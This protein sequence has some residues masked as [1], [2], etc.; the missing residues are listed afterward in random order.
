MSYGYRAVLPT[1]GVE[2]MLAIEIVREAV[3]ARE[4]LAEIRATVN[5]ALASYYAG[6]ALREY[7]FQFSRHEDGEK[8][9]ER[10]SQTVRHYDNYPKEIVNMYREGAYKSKQD[11]R[12][13][14][15]KRFDEYLSTT[16]KKWLLN[17]V[18]PFALI[19][20]ELFVF[21]EQAPAT[22]NE[23]SR[24]DEAGLLPESYVI[25]PQHVQ[26][27][28]ADEKGNIIWAAYWT[29]KKR[30]DLAIITDEEIAILK[31]GKPG[32]YATEVNGKPL[33][34]NPYRHGYRNDKGENV[35]PFLLIQYQKNYYYN[36]VIGCAPLQDVVYKSIGNLQFISMFI[37][38]VILHLSLKLRM[39]RDTLLNTTEEESGIGNATLI[40][41]EGGPTHVPT[42]YVELPEIELNTLIEIIFNHSPNSIFRAAR[43]SIPNGITGLSG[44]ALLM[45][46]TPQQNMLAN[47]SEFFQSYDE[48][49]CTYLKWGYSP[50]RGRELKVTYPPQMDN[51]SSTDIM[52]DVTAFVTNI[53]S[54][55]IPSSN[56]YNVL[57]MKKWYHAILPDITQAEREKGDEELAAWIEGGDLPDTVMEQLKTTKPTIGK[58]TAIDD[59]KDK[60]LKAV[61]DGL[62]NSPPE[63]PK[64]PNAN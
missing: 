13:T 46:A 52:A 19:L 32:K 6:N 22:G 64:T 8:L 48:R 25:F 1:L 9:A 43:L 3:K 4:C 11:T 10:R 55:K 31:D 40:I 63:S 14:G 53:S 12:M 7:I 24:A 23:E 44:I 15:E 16:Y 58:S 20:C 34:E 35:C 2:R 17:D 51:R 56:S 21:F 62:V 26:S 61:N 38:A 50:A 29:G 47:I 60:G 42:S 41:E 54:G 49:I 28:Q 27:Y 18:H 39:T 37:E 30:K 45:Y 33:Q 59:K 57:I 36:G 5:E